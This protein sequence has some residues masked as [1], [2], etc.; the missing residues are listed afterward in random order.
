M[1]WKLSNLAG[2]K[3]IIWL[4]TSQG[5]IQ[6]ASLLCSVALRRQLHPATPKYLHFVFI[7]NSPDCFLG[8]TTQGQSVESCLLLLSNFSNKWRLFCSWNVGWW[9]FFSVSFKMTDK[10][11]NA[12]IDHKLQ[13]ILTL[14]ETVPWFPFDTQI[15]WFITNDNSI[16]DFFHPKYTRNTRVWFQWHHEKR[17]LWKHTVANKY[18]ADRATLL[19]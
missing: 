5:I 18:F 13:W 4:P 2:L 3:T 17:I 9:N 10:T 14:E 11:L 1:L 19:V 6:V 12:G 7:N 8:I 15:I 16:T